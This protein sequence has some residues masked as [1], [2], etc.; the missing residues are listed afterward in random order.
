MSIDMLP[1]RSEGALP[2]GFKFNPD[3]ML[4]YDEQVQEYIKLRNYQE[5]PVPSFDRVPKLDIEPTFNPSNAPNT[6]IYAHGRRPRTTESG[7]KLRS[8]WSDDTEPVEIW[9]IVEK[10]RLLDG[11]GIVSSQ[12]VSKGTLGDIENYEDTAHYHSNHEGRLANEHSLTPYVSFSTDPEDLAKII[13]RRG[14][15]VKAGRDSV[16]V[17]ALVAPDRIMTGSLPKESEI[18]LVGGLAPDE[19]QAA[20]SVESFVGVMVADE[21]VTTIDGDKIAPARALGYWAIRS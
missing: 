13:V 1:T 20:Y 14:F 12:V 6:E 2:E 17:R 15:G 16:V 19:Y 11:T 9:R 5:A 18:V 4:D 3:L 21:E 7:K 10:D 8:E